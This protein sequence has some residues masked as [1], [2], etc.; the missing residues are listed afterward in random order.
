M[1]SA[2][3]AGDGTDALDHD[4][5]RSMCVLMLFAGHETTTNLL[6]SMMLMLL[7]RPERLA[8]LR[9]DPT[10]I[11]PAVEEALRHDGPIKIL[12]R[13][14]T[15]DLE[16]DGHAIRRGERV[17]LVL[18]AANRDPGAFDRPDDVD[19][20]RSPN[21]HLAFGKGPHACLGAQ[22]S[23][24]EARVCFEQ[25]LERMPEVRLLPDRPLEWTP[26]LA[27]RTLRT[28]HIETPRGEPT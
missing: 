15:E 8:T 21:V 27:A 18:S 10:A 24:I 26:T 3:A 20:A 11:R 1:I 28:L 5:L 4:E 13:W 12:H 14:V 23:R 17:F 6:A 22:L 16:I 25:V 9:A 2:L 19:L 7:R